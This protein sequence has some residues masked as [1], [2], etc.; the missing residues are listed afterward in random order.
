MGWEL[1]PPHLN[2]APHS[3]REGVIGVR[4]K[5]STHSVDNSYKYLINKNIFYGFT[6]LPCKSANCREQPD[7]LHSA[8]VVPVKL[9]PA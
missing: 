8:L 9:S 4:Y 5:E 6:K 3:S 7:N 1:A 2:R